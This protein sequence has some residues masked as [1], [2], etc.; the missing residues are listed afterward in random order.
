MQ[1]TAAIC[2]SSR[3]LTSRAESFELLQSR[4]NVGSEATERLPHVLLTVMAF[5]AAKH[6][7]PRTLQPIHDVR[8]GRPATR[9]LHTDEHPARPVERSTRLAV[10]WAEIILGLD[11]I[12]RCLHV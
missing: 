4:T 10:G 6:V 11:I 2:G 9:C 1:P 3:G 5:D 8:L 12:A 7:E